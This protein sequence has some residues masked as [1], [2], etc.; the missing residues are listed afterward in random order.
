MPF[1]QRLAWIKVQQNDKVHQQLSHL[2][3][4]SQSPEKK[5]TKGDNTTLK[6]L[7]NLYKSGHL[8]KASDGL[9][10]VSH[11]DTERGNHQSISVPTYMYPG[12]V[13]ALHLKLD[14]PS[15]LQLQKLSCRYFYSPGFARVIEEIST[16]CVVCA[17]LKQL[18]S[19]ST[20]ETQMFVLTFL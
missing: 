3:D 13:Q 15:K 20:V 7:H 11:I 10:T 19:E 14:H 12:L 17:S 4:S 1:I 5:K 18:F 2:I 8:K 6:R 16:K 9:I